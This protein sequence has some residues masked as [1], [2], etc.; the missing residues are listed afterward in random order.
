MKI[1]KPFDPRTGKNQNSSEMIQGQDGR[2]SKSLKMQVYKSRCQLKGAAPFLQI[3]L[4]GLLKIT[5][6]A[7]ILVDVSLLRYRKTI[8]SK[9]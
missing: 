8:S 2:S 6:F 3:I 9:S 1:N 7:I 4:P 5:F